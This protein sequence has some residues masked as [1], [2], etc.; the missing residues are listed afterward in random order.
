MALVHV[1]ENGFKLTGLPEPVKGVTGLVG[2]NG[3]GKTTSLL[4]LCG[5]KEPSVAW[6]KLIGAHKGAMAKYF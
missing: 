1:N 5:K 3:L 6:P 4:I 2:A